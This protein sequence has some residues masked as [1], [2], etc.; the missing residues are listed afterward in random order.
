MAADGHKLTEL[1]SGI[2]VVT[3]ETSSVRSS[4]S[5]SGCASA[6]ATRRSSR[7][8]SRTS[9]S[10]CCSREPT[11]FSSTEIEQIFDGLGADIN[12][13]TGKETT[14]V[15]TRFLDEHL[16]RA[17]DV[18]ADM[19]LRSTYPDI[20]SEREVVLEE[21]AMYEDE[22]SDKVHDVLSAAV[23]GDHPLGPPV[24]GTRRRDR[25]RAGAGH[26]RLPRRPLPA[27][28]ILVIAAA[29]DLEH[30]R[31]VETGEQGLR[32]AEP[33]AAERRCCGAGQREADGALP[34]EGDRAVPHLPRRPGH[35]AQRRPPLRPARCWTRSSA[36]R[37]PRACSRRCAR[38]AASPTRSTPGPAST[39]TPVRSALYVGT[40]QD[41]V[42][43]ALEV[44]GD[45]LRKLQDTVGQRG[46]AGARQ[47]AREGPH[48]AVDGVDAGAH[49][50]ARP[51]RPDG[52]SRCCRSTRSSRRSTRSAC[53]DLTALASDLY[54]P[55]GC[56]RPAIGRDEGVFRS[57]LAPVNPA[58]L[59][60]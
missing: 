10:T 15:Y 44:I 32:T 28:P 46:R 26:R 22:P 24:I 33:G 14:S 43:E 29:G 8:G 54:A 39:W 5:G 52:Q 18:M 13:G 23:F 60:A 57:A 4:R 25:D 1:D 38:S 47:G 20:E 3:E 16:D 53:D 49:E 59:A 30:E 35:P 36:A 17:F 2:R 45:E 41:N 37:R 21:I 48:G 56:R 58:L 55:S 50:P 51:L 31:L 34:P 27:G 6:R 19:L 40:R 9:S 11:R 7:P 42:G 12:A